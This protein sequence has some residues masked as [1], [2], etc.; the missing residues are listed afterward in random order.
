MGSASA[1]TQGLGI[2]RTEGLDRSAC[3]R[4]PL[5]GQR[6][7]DGASQSSAMKRL[8]PTGSRA[9]LLPESSHTPLYPSPATAGTARSEARRVGKACARTF[10]TRWWHDKSKQNT[11]H[12]PSPPTTSTPR[13]THPNP[14]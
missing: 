10:R 6:P 7:Q 2:E 12:L 11:I 13:T 8:Q 4:P 1:V 14:T 3:I 9:H 5:V